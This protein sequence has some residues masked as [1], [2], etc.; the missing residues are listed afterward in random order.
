[1][2]GIV[3]IA[4]NSTARYMAFTVCLT[5][6]KTPVNTGIEWAIGSDRIVGRN[7]LAKRCIE[8][9]AEWLFFLDDDHAF[10]QNIL[11]RLLSHEKDIVASLYL[12]RIKPFAP[13]AYSS[14]DEEKGVYIPVDLTNYGKEDLVPIRAAGTG[15]M[16]IRSE[17][18]RTLDEPWF[19]LKDGI[20]SEDLVFC[21]KAIEAGFEI[22]CDLGAPLGHIDPVI[23]WPSYFEQEKEWGVGFNLADNFSL[24]IPIE[25]PQKE[26]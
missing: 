21:D 20:G 1:M 8:Q 5:V 10:D 6:L 9:G 19:H 3:G 11:M 24:Y 15:G 18:F 4:C 16:L 23:I 7:N 2:S 14:F 12:Q 26:E 17:V 25:K 13:I 22:Y